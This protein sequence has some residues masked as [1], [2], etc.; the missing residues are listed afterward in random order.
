MKCIKG[1]P[2]L[3]IVDIK[4]EILS[5]MYSGILCLYKCYTFACEMF[6]FHINAWW[7]AIFG[8]KYAI[9]IICISISVY[10]YKRASIERVRGRMESAHII[11]EKIVSSRL[12]FVCSSVA[13]MWK[14][15][16]VGKMIATWIVS[17]WPHFVNVDMMCSLSYCHIYNSL[18]QEPLAF[19]LLFSIVLIFRPLQIL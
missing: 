19:L 17:Y 15:K 14:W 3:F 13:W 7:Y 11:T 18:C 10:T 5:K 4:E 16:Y 9:L 2:L 1:G 8:Q 12:F 6:M